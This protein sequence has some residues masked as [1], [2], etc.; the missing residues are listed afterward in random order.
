MSRFRSWFSDFWMHMSGFR[1][2]PFF[3]V[4]GVPVCGRLPWLFPVSR[5]WVGGFLWAAFGWVPGWL[6]D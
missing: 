6:V 1:R 4:G 5:A 2:D 3:C